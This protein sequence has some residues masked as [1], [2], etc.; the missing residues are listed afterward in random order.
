MAEDSP[1]ALWSLPPLAPRDL[2]QAGG[3]VVRAGAPI[4]WIA[5]G[6]GLGAAGFLP[7][8]G[9]VRHLRI[10]S[11]AGRAA[12]EAAEPDELALLAL[13][14]RRRGRLDAD[15]VLS[16]A[17]IVRLYRGVC[18]L[19]GIPAQ[20]LRMEQVVAK[21]L[22]ARC[23]ECA[24]AVA[25]FCALLGDVAARLALASGALG[26][27]YLGGVLVPELA[28][29]FLRSPFRRRFECHGRDREL[30]RAIPTFVVRRGIAPA[31][32]DPA[33]LAS[34]SNSLN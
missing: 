24:R 31:P 3:G 33:R 12:L 23:P 6:A 18:R 17:G 34:R 26:G 19:R 15:D 5:P 29:W 8:P 32:L 20:R 2:L 14:R 22:A 25:I 27:V 30:M 28:E 13:L 1:V 16:C 7:L 9:G 10:E 4:A 21:A 11:L